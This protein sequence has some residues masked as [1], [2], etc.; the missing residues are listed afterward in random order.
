MLNLWPTPK[1]LT[2]EAI[3]SEQSGYNFKCLRCLCNRK[4]NECLEAWNLISGYTTFH[5]TRRYLHFFCLH[6][7]LSKEAKCHLYM[8]QAFQ[9]KNKSYSD[10]TDSSHVYS[11]FSSYSSF[12]QAL[13]YSNQGLTRSIFFSDI[14]EII[15]RQVYCPLRF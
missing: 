13:P 1:R 15:F 7:S 2:T 4:I 10:L 12:L 5:N 6:S 11:F 9:H 3:M 14:L 8:F